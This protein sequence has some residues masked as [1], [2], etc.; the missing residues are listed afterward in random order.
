M[1]TFPQTF[2]D[3][4]KIRYLWPEGGER[5]LRES[6]DWDKAARFSADR[7][8]RDA[9]IWTGYVT[10]GAALID[11]A[12]RRPIDRD[13]LVHPIFFCYRHSLEAAMKWTIGLYG[14]HFD[15]FL[16]EQNHNLL[17]L[18]G[19]CKRILL[20]TREAEDPGEDICAVE[21]VIKEFHDMD[22][23]ATAFRYSTNRDGMRI[24]LPDIRIDLEN[25]QQVME[26]A[27]NFFEGADG[28]LDDLCANSPYYE[29]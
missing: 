3:I 29:G 4:L 16:D 21:Q 2:S 14:R 5:L 6:T 25:L 26:A 8:S 28:M 17:T 22:R 11:E 19:L 27:N 18:W 1:R 10:A 12:E 24:G 20:E 13:L 23:Y 9:L 15:V 7:L